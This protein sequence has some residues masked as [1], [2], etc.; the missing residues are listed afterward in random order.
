MASRSGMRMRSVSTKRGNY[1][2]F[3]CNWF[4][5]DPWDAHDDQP[6]IDFD[7]EGFCRVEF[8]PLEL[9]SLPQI[10]NYLL[11]QGWIPTQFTPKG[12]PQLPKAG[13]DS[14]EAERSLSTIEGETGK[15][16]AER[17]I[18]QARRGFLL[19][20]K[21]ERKGQLNLMRRDGRITA[22]IIVQGTPTGRSR[23][24]GVVNVASPK[25]K[26]G[27]AIRT[28]YRAPS[29]RKIVG[30]DAVALEMRVMSHF[31]N[32]PDFT[33][34]VVVD[35]DVHT[36]FWNTVKDFIDTRDHCKN[37]EYA[38]IYGALDPKLGSMADRKPLGW[39]DKRAGAE[40][41]RRFMEGIPALGSLIKRVQTTAEKRGYLVGL[42]GRKL[43]FRSKHSLL[44][45]LFQSAGA[46]IMKTATVYRSNFV[47]FHCEEDNE[48]PTHNTHTVVVS[49]AITHC[50]PPSNLIVL[51]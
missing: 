14:E 25:A 6:L 49:G 51:P 23:H 21:D 12:S 34:A 41:R 13:D 26:Y 15:L 28:C 24:T 11:N 42:D 10:K 31:L 2:A 35:D 47:G 17:L 38:F 50:L 4:G 29:G 8:R 40:I 46:V 37:V 19:N 36:L 9:T 18:L 39:S 22:G 43:Q 5:L 7:H 3:V 30:V 16:I 33:H 44:N 45:L 48:H 20:I 27:K 32:D 1:T